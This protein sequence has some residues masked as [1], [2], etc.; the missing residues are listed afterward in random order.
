MIKYKIGDHL[1][2]RP[3]RLSSNGIKFKNYTQ[4]FKVKDISLQ[5]DTYA[6]LCIEDAEKRVFEAWSDAFLPDEEKQGDFNIF[7]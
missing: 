3:G 6:L 5:A 2:V 7:W 4:P 1:M